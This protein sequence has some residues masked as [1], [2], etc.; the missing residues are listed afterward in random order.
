[1]AG[2]PSTYIKAEGGKLSLTQPCDNYRAFMEF[3]NI[4]LARDLFDGKVNSVAAVGLGDIRIGGMVSMVDNVNRILDRVSL[5][6]A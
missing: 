2:C 6:L 1:M 3:D 5:Y 4:R